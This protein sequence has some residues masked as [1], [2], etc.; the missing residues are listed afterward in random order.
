VEN[1]EIILTDIARDGVDWIHLALVKTVMN[2]GLLSLS[3]FKNSA[4]F[5]KL[6]VFPTSVTGPD[7]VIEI[8]SS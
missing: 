2:S 3:I 4:M 6:G 1:I 5:R 8:N 7:P